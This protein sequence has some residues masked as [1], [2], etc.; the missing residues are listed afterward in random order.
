MLNSEGKSNSFTNKQALPLLFNTNREK[1]ITKTPN[2]IECPQKLP[3][4]KR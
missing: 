1:Q 2:A 3:N 4:K